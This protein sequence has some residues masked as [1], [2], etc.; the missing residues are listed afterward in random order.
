MKTNSKALLNAILLFAAVLAFSGVRANGQGAANS[1]A[2]PLQSG[3]VPA[4]ITKAIDETQ[5][6]TLKSSV[7]PLARP[8][9]DQGPVDDSMPMNRML[10]VLKRSMEQESALI[11]LMVGQHSTN[12]PNYH[13]WLTPEEFGAEFGPAD[14]DIQVITSWLESHGFQVAKVSKGKIAIEFSGTAAQVKQAFHTEIHKFLVNGETHLANASNPQIPAALAPVIHGLA[15]LNNFRAKQEHRVVGE[16]S[17]SI[18]SSQAKPVNPELTISNPVGY[19]LGPTDFATI[20]NVL[21]LWNATPTAVDGTGQSIAVI[22]TSNINLE[23]VQNFRTVFGLP[24]G[25]AA[26]TPIV[27]IDGA[28]PG[29]VQSA[30]TEALLDVEWSGAVAKGAQIHFVIAADTDIA[31]GFLLAI[32]NV[33][34]R[35]SDP[36]LSL[37]FGDCEANEGSNNGPNG[38]WEPLW[39][40]AAAQGITVTVSTGDS[41]SAG[42]E[43]DTLP[44][45]NPATT[46]L[47]VNGFASTPFNVAVGGTD[48]NDAGNQSTYFSNTNAPNTL[49]SAL[50]YIPESSWNQSCTNAAFGANAEANCNSTVSAN[51]AAVFTVGGGGGASSVYTKPAFQ[52]FISAA[53]GM[54]A[55]GARDLPDVSLFASSGGPDLGVSGSSQSFYVVCE[56]DAVPSPSC[57]GSTF[58]FLGVG[59]TSAATPS[60]AGIMALVNQKNGR[61][62]NANFVL[63]K[64]AEMQYAAT[65]TKTPACESV[66]SPLPIASCTFNDITAGTIAMPCVKNSPNCNPTTGTDTVGVLSGFSTTPGYDLATGL[67]SVNA[68]NL[69]NNW[70]TGVS[71]F[72]PTTV[73]LS[74]SP[75]TITA[76]TTV[77]VNITVTP[78]TA[79][80][81]VGLVSNAATGDGVA[82]FT[83]GAG[84]TVVNGTT[85]QLTGGTYQV[86]ARYGGDGTFAPSVSAPITVNVAKAASTT[87][88]SVEISIGGGNYATFTSGA[89]PVTLFLAANINPSGDLLPTGTVNFVDTFNGT[90]TTVAS[91]VIVNQAFEAFTASGI[92]TFAPGN[93]SIVANYSGDTTFNASSSAPVTFTIT[94]TAGPTISSISPT[95][96]TAGGAAFTLTVNGANFANGA[97]VNFGTN[98]ALTPTSI[99]STQIQ[100]T[101][102]ATDIATAGTKAVTVTSGGT[103]SNSVNFTVNAGSS[104]TFAIAESAVV[105]SSTTGASVNSTVTVTPSGGFTGMV[106]VT[107]STSTP[108]VTCTPSPLNINVPGASAVTGQLSCSVLATSTTLTASNASP[109]RMLEAKTATPS[110]GDKG[111]WT[112]SAGTGFAALFLLFLPGGRK[113]YRAALGLGL[114][115]I[116]SF[117]LGCGGG[118]APPPP[119]PPTSTVTKLTVAGAKVASGTAF[120]FS[121]SVT[122][123][124]PTGQ[125][126]LFDGATMI[127]ATATVAGGTATPTAPALA[128]GT[129]MISAHYLGDATTA[130]SASGTINMTVTGSTTVTV[131]TNPVASPAAPALNVTIN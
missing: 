41:G 108:G 113:R 89:A 11:Q 127:G 20:Y 38:L 31:S 62:G 84:G 94:G 53:N 125:V 110:K 1:T 126:E 106:G 59:G 95:S 74:L 28:D 105:L 40:Q 80:G 39:E 51:E 42:C 100:V 114:V 34:D 19:G 122:G 77:T 73:T 16:F 102:P 118:S 99:T 109:D 121:V 116:L 96:A 9:F 15:P 86:T 81:D 8:E 2:T 119:P 107:A 63:Y 45:P 115:C 75:T 98:G 25:G 46:G 29:I 76:G 43:D 83:L 52:S 64:L 55:D 65:T 27:V 47:A 12:S 91:G 72:T 85:D 58:N 57:S 67:G 61:Q 23:D 32:F 128:V 71:A 111:W 82:G 130:A 88:A 117:T 79:T 93:H 30:E 18:E 22:G 33:V 17:K 49:A 36:I 50:G 69:V 37:S 66:A 70:S 97:T 4:R 48:F 24:T 14:A 60:F 7:H 104:G 3:P 92:S 120:S 35:N 78:S 6:V 68:Q 129:H 5:L 90:P 54:P 10:V 87:V 124:T 103:T 44:A 101:V 112:L 26:N 56:A 123:G 13:K 21:P 131:T